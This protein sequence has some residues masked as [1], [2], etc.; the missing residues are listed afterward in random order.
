MSNDD[1]SLRKQVEIS[2]EF[3]EHQHGAA[4]R[5][6]NVQKAR[7]YHHAIS[8]VEDALD[9]AWRTDQAFDERWDGLGRE[10]IERSREARKAGVEESTLHEK[11]MQEHEERYGNPSLLDRVL[12]WWVGVRGR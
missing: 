12:E 3:L 6:G 2:K 9:E 11:R 1:S 8:I 4:V 7:D 5:H 10:F